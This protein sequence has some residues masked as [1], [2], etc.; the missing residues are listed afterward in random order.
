MVAFPRALQAL[1]EF[2]EL[3]I[4]QTADLVPCF[5]TRDRYGRCSFSTCFFPYGACPA[6]GWRHPRLSPF[7]SRCGLAVLLVPQLLL[8][9]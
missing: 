8:F 5:P 1:G 2:A 7:L 4:L 6:I 3:V 9:V